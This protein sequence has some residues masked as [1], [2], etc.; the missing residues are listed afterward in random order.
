MLI[1]KVLDK[2]SP[3]PSKDVTELQNDAT[4]WFDEKVKSAQNKQEEGKVLNLLDKFLLQTETWYFRT[5]CAA[6]FVPLVAY[7]QRIMAGEGEE[8]LPH[9]DLNDNR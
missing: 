5:I 4:V 9:D 6:A 1:Y 8:D 7:F 3:M 2:V